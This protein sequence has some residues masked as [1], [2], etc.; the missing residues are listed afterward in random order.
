MIRFNQYMLILKHDQNVWFLRF[1]E[2]LNFDLYPNI[3]WCMYIL[4][5]MSIDFVDDD[6]NDH[7]SHSWVH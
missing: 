6:S 7:T 3:C 4:L 2:V 1:P 5:M